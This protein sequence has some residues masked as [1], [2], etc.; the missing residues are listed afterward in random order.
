MPPTGVDEG[1]KAPRP[2]PRWVYSAWTPFAVGFL[3]FASTIGND[4]TYDDRTIVLKNPRI[5]SPANVVEIWTTDWWYD[6]PNPEEAVRDP[7][8]DRLYRPLTLWTFALNYAAGGYAPGG[9]HFVNVLLHAVASALLVL[10]ARRLFHDASLATVAGLIFA[11]HPIHV[12]AIAGIVGRAEVLAGVLLLAG[13]LVCLPRRGELT[14]AA[15]WRAAPLF[16][17]ALFAKE[18]AICYP[19]VVPAFAAAGGALPRLRSRRALGVA[20][21][22]LI[23]LIVYFPLRF[24]ALESQLIR[25]RMLVNIL[26]PLSDAD[27]LERF[28]GVFTILGHYTRL[29]I[30]PRVLLSDYGLA[31]I[32]PSAGVTAMTLLGFASAAAIVFGLIAAVRARPESDARRWGWLLVAFLAGYALI[33]NAVILIGV[34]LAERLFYW[35][36]VPPILLGAALGVRAWRR[37]CLPGGR[38]AARAELIRV[39]ALALLAALAL[40]SVTRSFDWADDFTLFRSDVATNT[41]SVQINTSLAAHFVAAAAANRDPQVRAA[42]LHEAETLLERALRIHPRHADALRQLALAKELRG[43][44]DA[45]R[46]LAGRAMELAPSDAR[47]RSLVARLDAGAAEKLA[48]AQ[49]LEAEVAAAP[50]DVDKRLELFEIYC[51]FGRTAD[52]AAQAEAAYA[53]APDRA[54][55]VRAYAQALVI[56]LRAEEAIAAYRRA[57]ELDDTDWQSHASLAKLL[58]D[59]DADAHAQQIYRHAYRAYELKPD[60]PRTHINLAEALVVLKD[61]PGAIDVLRGV[62]SGLSAGDPLISVIEERIAQLRK[63]FP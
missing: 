43:D 50:Q 56:T 34:S 61:I 54:D 59:Q 15:A 39:A 58:A 51:D 29:M 13:L 22:L 46:L 14:A 48:R 28:L 49:A 41:D 45:A 17:A 38:L 31:V 44:L 36:S 5:Q 27:A 40:R 3:C 62:Q 30:V 55:V 63:E 19:L 32:D 26:N 4:F 35:P 11:V 7:S 18:T 60:D 33:S 21:A 12:E 16:L 1:A 10:V 2:A 53:L 9:Y 57:L 8:R 20:T 24:F 42:A 37:W 25:E 6:V 52:A 47:N 23:P